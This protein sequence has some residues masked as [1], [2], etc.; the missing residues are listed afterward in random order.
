MARKPEPHVIEAR[1]VELDE[2]ITEYVAL[3]DEARSAKPQPQLAAAVTAMKAAT[4]LR[5]ER[6]NCRAELKAMTITDPLARVRFMGQRSGAAGSWVAAKD[7]YREERELKAEIDAEAK[8]QAEEASKD[9]P[10]L[11]EE[12]DR[13]LTDMPES[14]RATLLAKWLR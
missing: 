13:I 5:G 3:A 7:L 8:R 1:I 12:M 14:L 10:K 2:E 11:M 6:A 4:M 9:L